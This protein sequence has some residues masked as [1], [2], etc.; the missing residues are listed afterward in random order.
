[1][2]NPNVEISSH[3]EHRMK[4]TIY[5]TMQEIEKKDSIF[6]SDIFGEFWIG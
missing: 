6:E 2:K 3:I 5:E 4:E 1:M